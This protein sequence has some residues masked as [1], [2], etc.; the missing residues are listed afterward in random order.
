MS[1]DFGPAK[2]ISITA[3]QDFNWHL[4]VDITGGTVPA[5]QE[6]FNYYPFNTYT[7][8]QNAALLNYKKF[9][10]ELRFESDGS[11][12]FQWVLGSLYGHQSSSLFDNQPGFS[13][14]GQEIW[15]SG[16]YQADTVSRIDEIAGFGDLTLRL[17]NR[18]DI[19]G[20]IRYA[21]DREV[22]DNTE[23]V[24]LFAGS[25]TPHLEATEHAVTYLGSARYHFDDDQMGYLRYATGYRPGGPNF[26]GI[27]P[28]TGQQVGSPYFTS[29]SLKS[30]EAGY[31]ASLLGGRLVVDV[32]G[33]HIDWS[34]IQIATYIFPFG[35]VENAPGGASIWGSELAISG[36]PVQPLLLSGTLTYQD[37][38]LREAQPA[39]GAFAGERLPMVPHVTGTLSADYTFAGLA[40]QPSVGTSM[41]Y[42]DARWESFDQNAG[43]PQY[44]L[45]DY[46]V[47]DLRAGLHFGSLDLQLYARNVLNKLGQIS[48]LTGNSQY[49]QVTFVQPRTIGLSLTKQF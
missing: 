48:A 14:A 30:Y 28:V 19:I 9:S 23:A 13:P 8:V 5:L 42:V 47:V 12:P 45:P 43:Y 10:Q 26:V 27:S 25:L 29:D 1:Y 44:H 36:R 7:A 41:R 18:F 32:A 49:A 24:G 11:G 46:A 40:W 17:T 39:L 4:A 6:F 15:N 22:S 21:R 35:F 31:K 20:G 38:Y 16:I 33:Y 34:N 3:Y 37:A 2:L